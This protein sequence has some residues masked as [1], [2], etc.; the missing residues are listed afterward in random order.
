MI[1]CHEV[2]AYVS[3]NCF[4]LSLLYNLY[5]SSVFF[6]YLMNIS[7]RK[8][9]MNSSDWLYMPHFSW[10][11]GCRVR[12]R[13]YLCNWV[14]ALRLY[15]MHTCPS[16]TKLFFSCERRA[17]SFPLLLQEANTEEINS[18][19]TK[20]SWAWEFH[21]QTETCYAAGHEHA[22]KQ[23]LMDRWKTHSEGALKYPWYHYDKCWLLHKMLL[24][25]TD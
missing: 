4:Y 1:P 20:I 3:T 14:L 22:A 11:L 17:V 2:W 6:Y 9:A 12:E 5:C 7:W 8:T 16:C 18:S 23:V 19:R 24:L 13:P 21:A 10:C 15:P 25:K